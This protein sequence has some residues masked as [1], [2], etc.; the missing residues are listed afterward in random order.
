MMIGKSQI[1]NNLLPANK[2]LQYAFQSGMDVAAVFLFMAQTQASFL[3]GR[4]IVAKRLSNQ[5]IP[6]TN[7]FINRIR[8]LWASF[9]TVFHGFSHKLLFFHQRAERRPTP[10]CRSHRQV[11]TDRKRFAATKQPRY[12][13]KSKNR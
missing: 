10:F 8:A 7:R 5:I 11:R 1:S 13:Q 4:R 3:S 2:P 6:L 12:P 9:F